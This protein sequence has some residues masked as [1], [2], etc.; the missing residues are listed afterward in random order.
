MWVGGLWLQIILFT[1]IH[2]SSN[3]FLSQRLPTEN[4]NLT[5]YCK[6]GIMG[7]RP[8]AAKLL[9][10]WWIIII[11]NNNFCSQRLPTQNAN[12]TFYSQVC[13]L[14]SRPLTA[15]LIGWIIINNNFC[16]QRPPT[17]N[18]NLTIKVRFAFWLG[19]LWLQKWLDE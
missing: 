7:S 18:A 3:N 8:L 9:D 14:G 17:R 1:I 16:S 12:L 11:I 6:V 2:Y 5:F 4:A 10:E 15:K 13:I 19:G